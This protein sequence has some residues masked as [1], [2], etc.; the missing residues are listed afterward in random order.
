MVWQVSPACVNFPT[1]DPL[2]P[3]SSPLVP[4][5]LVLI[6]LCVHTHQTIWDISVIASQDGKVSTFF[7]FHLGG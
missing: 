6:M 7:L 4:L 5:T 3:R 2:V 1:V